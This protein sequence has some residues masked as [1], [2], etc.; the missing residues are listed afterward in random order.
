M[1]EMILPVTPKYRI[2]FNKYLYLEIYRIKV[3]KYVYNILFY[4]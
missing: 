2:I 1:E 3:I 4:I